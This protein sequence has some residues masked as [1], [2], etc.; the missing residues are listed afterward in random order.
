MLHLNFFLIFNEALIPCIQNVIGQMWVV[1]GNALLSGGF[2]LWF[3]SVCAE[4]RAGWRCVQWACSGGNLCLK[5]M[6]WGP[7]ALLQSLK[8]ERPTETKKKKSPSL[9]LA[10]TRFHFNLPTLSFPP[11]MCCTCLSPSHTISPSVSRHSVSPSTR[12]PHPFSP[13]LLSDESDRSRRRKPGKSAAQDSPLAFHS[14]GTLCLRCSIKMLMALAT[15][16]R[17]YCSTNW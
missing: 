6:L 2:L 16:E 5:R 4:E 8:T 1:Y 13:W 17:Y 15:R 14:L 12:A 3:P 10:H 9:S 11:Q 7:G